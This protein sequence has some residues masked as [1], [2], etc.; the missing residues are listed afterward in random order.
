MINY[1]KIKLEKSKHLIRGLE[2]LGCSQVGMDIV[3]AHNAGQRVFCC[4]CD[5]DEVIEVNRV[6]CDKPASTLLNGYPLYPT[7]G[8]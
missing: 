5:L 2:A 8:V 4:T 3:H 7:K 6:M 1:I